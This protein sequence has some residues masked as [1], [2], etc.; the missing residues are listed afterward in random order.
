MQGLL[1]H[2]NAAQSIWKKGKEI[3]QNR[4]SEKTNFY[5]IFDQGVIHL[6]RTQNFSKT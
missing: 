3:K 6:V 1:L 4:Q 5:L 2:F